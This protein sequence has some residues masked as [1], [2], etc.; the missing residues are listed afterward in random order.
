MT[1][2]Y[3]FWHW[4]AAG[5]DPAEY[6][7]ALRAFHHALAL[8][9]SRT[10]RLDRAPYDGPA[11]YEDWYPV[12]D[13]TALGA[14]NARAVDAARAATHDAAARRSGGGA[15][16][17]YRQLQAGRDDTTVSWCDARPTEAADA[18]VW[19]RQMVLG[20]APEFLVTRPHDGGRSVRRSAL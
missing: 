13:W 2:A 6:E 20:P 12:A 5:A 8:P 17:V 15:A 3:V 18:A 4:P 14:L 16:G 10:Y 1:L 11:M 19:Q 9:G 7:Q